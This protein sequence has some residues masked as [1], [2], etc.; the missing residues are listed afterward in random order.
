[1]L[2]CGRGGWIACWA[3]RDALLVLATDPLG[4]FDTPPPLSRLF[5]SLLRGVF[6][7]PCSSGLGREVVT[8]GLGELGLAGAA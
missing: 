1:V 5:A 7:P 4:A 6:A 8:F 3:A 2:L